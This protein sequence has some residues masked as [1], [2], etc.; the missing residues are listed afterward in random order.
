MF[1]VALLRTFFVSP[2]G[3]RGFIS[4]V[5]GMLRPAASASGELGLDLGANGLLPVRVEKRTVV[6]AHAL[7]EGR[8]RSE[9]RATATAAN[10]G[11][12]GIRTANFKKRWAAGSASDTR[13]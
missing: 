3:G 5:L 10:G 13:F 1:R 6:I 2:G 12:Q 4:S 11:V 8:T 9:N 7:E